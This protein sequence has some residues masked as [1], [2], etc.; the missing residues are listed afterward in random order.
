MAKRWYYNSRF[1]A[2]KYFFPIHL[3]LIQCSTVMQQ[4]KLFTHLK[5]KTLKKTPR[6]QYIMARF[7]QTL[8]I[9]L[10]QQDDAIVLVHQ[11]LREALLP[12]MILLLSPGNNIQVNSLHVCSKCTSPLSRK[13]IYLLVHGALLGQLRLMNVQYINDITRCHTMI[14]DQSFQQ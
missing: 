3:T 4:T 7:T 11:Q 1:W 9:W 6:W 5:Q 8:Y 10:W 12:D 2:Q 13:H 14:T